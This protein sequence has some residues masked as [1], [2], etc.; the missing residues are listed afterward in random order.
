MYRLL[1]HFLFQTFYVPADSQIF[2]RRGDMIGIH[3]EQ[4]TTSGTIAYENVMTA[5][6]NYSKGI[7]FHD[8]HHASIAYERD[9]GWNDGFVITTTNSARKSVAIRVYI[10]CSKG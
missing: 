3:Y 9:S 6:R 2:V 1:K 8:L 5:N 10:D 7:T 4:N